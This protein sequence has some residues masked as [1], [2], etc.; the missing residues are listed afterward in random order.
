MSS[1]K[2]PEGFAGKHAKKDILEELC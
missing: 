2:K 1:Q